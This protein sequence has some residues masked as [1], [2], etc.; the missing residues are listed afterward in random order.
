MAQAKYDESGCD[1]A[2]EK[3]DSMDVEDVK[4]YLKQLIR[5]NMTVG[6]E[7]IKDN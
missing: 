3:I 4:R 1:T 7:I 5:G 2:L 6:I